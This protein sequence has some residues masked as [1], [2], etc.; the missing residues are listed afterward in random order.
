MDLPVPPTVERE[1]IADERFELLPHFVGLLGDELV[2]QTAVGLRLVLLA[3]DDP[4]GKRDLAGARGR[5]DA[6]S[7]FLYGVAQFRAETFVP[8]APERRLIRECL[9]SEIL[10]KQEVRSQ[11]I[12]HAV[13]SQPL[14]SSTTNARTSNAIG[15]GLEYG[16]NESCA[17]NVR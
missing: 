15:Y 7:T 6:V 10:A 12:V 8:R 11:V 2:F 14:I 17:A 9:E 1:R 4:L 5:G 3:D 16:A 13:S